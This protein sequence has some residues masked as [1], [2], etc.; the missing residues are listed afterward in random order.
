MSEELVPIQEDMVTRDV[1]QYWLDVAKDQRSMVE[2]LAQDLE[3]ALNMCRRYH[4]V[5]DSLYM[6]DPH[7]AT[8]RKLLIKYHM[9]TPGPSRGGVIYA[10]TQ[11]IT[12][13]PDSIEGTV[14]TQL[15][16]ET[17]QDDGGAIALHD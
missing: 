12:D 10:G 3:S 17:W 16:I 5:L 9:E 11:N 13:H 15:E 1:A 6:N 14:D 4:D 8:L 2:T 7:L